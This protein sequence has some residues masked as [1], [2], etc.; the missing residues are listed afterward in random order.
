MT[1]CLYKE[2]KQFYLRQRQP[3]TDTA[4]EADKSPRLS[5]EINTG[6]EH[7]ARTRRVTEQ[8]DEIAD[9]LINEAET[10]R[11]GEGSAVSAN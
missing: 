3:G 6:G 2:R 5:G 11:S 10:L 8:R 9:V 4:A 1:S 7:G